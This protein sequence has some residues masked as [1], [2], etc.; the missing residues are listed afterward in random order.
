MPKLK[1]RVK[2]GKQGNKA[3]C[4][5]HLGKKKAFTEGNVSFDIQN[6]FLSISAC[7]AFTFTDC[8]QMWG[9][10]E[11]RLNSNTQIGLP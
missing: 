6:T 1:I 5:L 11:R 8:A 4:S 7:L 10:I 9:E 2:G 3:H